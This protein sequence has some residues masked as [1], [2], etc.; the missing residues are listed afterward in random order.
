MQQKTDN[1]ASWM[2][3][4]NTIKLPMLRK[5]RASLVPTINETSFVS[6][7]T[8]SSSSSLS[9]MDSQST[10]ITV[11]SNVSSKSLSPPVTQRL[12]PERPHASRPKSDCFPSN[13]QSTSS[14]FPGKRLSSQSPLA[15]RVLSV[16]D[17][18]WVHQSLLLLFG[19]VGI[20]E[21]PC[22]GMITVHHHLDGY[23]PT[24]WPISEG[25]FKALARLD[26]GP[27]RIR[28][29]YNASKIPSFSTSMTLNLLPL[30][31]SPP[32]HL[33]ILIG[34]D[35][36]GEY[37]HQGERQERGKNGTSMAIKKLR[38]AAYLA[39]AFTGE[40]M[41]RNKLGRRCFRLEE[42]WNM[43]TLSN[44]TNSVMKNIAKV[45][46]IRSERTK[47]EIRELE[48]SQ[49][50]ETLREVVHMAIDQYFVNT[51]AQRHVAVVV[52]D[53]K[54]DLQLPNIYNKSALNDGIGIVGSRALYTLPTCVEE[55]VPSLS[56]CTRI[57]CSS[58]SHN[59]SDSE[60]FWEA[61]TNA[62]GI[63]LEAFLSPQSPIEP[64]N[65]THVNRTFVTK[66]PYSLKNKSPGQRLSLPQ[67]ECTWP[68]VDCLRFRYHPSF[69]LPT[70]PMPPSLPDI[71][72]IYAVEN[73]IVVGASSGITLVLIYEGDVYRDYIEYT[74]K[75]EREAM[76]TEDVIRRKLPNLH[77]STLVK[78]K[79]YSAGQ[80]EVTVDDFYA[81]KGRKMELPNGCG[82]A[83]QSTYSGCFSNAELPVQEIILRS[84]TAGRMLTG[85]R[86]YHSHALHGLD[87]LYED[88]SN[89]LFGQNGRGVGDVGENENEGEGEDKKKILA[90]DF[91]FDTRKGEV[92]MGFCVR[93]GRYIDGIEILT[94]FGRRSPTFG[95]TES[96]FITTLVPPRGRTI[97]GVAGTS[98]KRVDGFSI[99]Y[100]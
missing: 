10:S 99:L 45:H 1:Q 87:F 41:F 50:G 30:A 51:S 27:N 47:D 83:F 88:G 26:P 20:P 53:A 65:L 80:G 57:G 92:L 54:G 5:S 63:M 97:A 17:N 3:N 21:S 8:S 69:R 42:E 90:S 2:V 81:A 23:P 37:D 36:N 44:R 15:P 55:V 79:I 13:R 72:Q 24:K 14:P 78:L 59:P 61:A 73:G 4:N 38:M 16:Q 85:I 43:D 84:L 11:P 56:D 66:E 29:E 96:R 91:G 60:F 68:R 40:Q 82:T 48:S 6:V 25:Y 7:E 98:S 35:S 18:Q 71:P 34:R 52:L 86:I 46:V 75:P 58:S 31:A 95:N 76:L 77:K 67:E 93:S 12:F 74:A 62:L 39:Q 33:A 32:L 94:S 9:A 89:Q 22:T 100:K 19:Q 64:R 70:D 28:L 49:N